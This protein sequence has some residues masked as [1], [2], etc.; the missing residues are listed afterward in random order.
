MTLQRQPPIEIPLGG[1][2]DQSAGELFRGPNV[3]ADCSNGSHGKAPELRK[4]LGYTRLDTATTTH[5]ETVDTVLVSLGVDL[6]GEL[7]I[8]GRDH[9]YGVAAP[10]ASVDGHAIVLRGPSHV[11]NFQVGIL[12]TTA[13]GEAL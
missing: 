6:G 13:L 3:L 11:G 5:G 4:R 10:D 12:H 2:L 8:V 1:S 9:V 7:V